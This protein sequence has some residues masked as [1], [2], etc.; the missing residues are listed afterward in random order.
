M[1]LF[2]LRPYGV[3]VTTC[4]HAADNNILVKYPPHL[5]S[6]IPL[7]SGTREIRLLLFHYGVCMSAG[8]EMGVEADVRWGGERGGDK[9]EGIGSGCRSGVVLPHYGQE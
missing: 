7:C 2:G 3:A 1:Q 8:G 9:G 4:N 6:I 5:Y